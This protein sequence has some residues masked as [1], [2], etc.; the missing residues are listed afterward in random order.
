MRWRFLD[1]VFDL[2]Q[3]DRKIADIDAWW[4]AFQAKTDALAALFE[5]QASW[6]LVTW[7]Q[8]ELGRIHP[9]LMWEFGPAVT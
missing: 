8:A 9:E 1:D 4:D 6:D 5:Q 3:R 7:M 2:A